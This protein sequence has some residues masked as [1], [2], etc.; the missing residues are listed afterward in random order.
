MQ[1]ELAFASGG[2]RHETG[3]ALE[4]SCRG[5]AYARKGCNVLKFCFKSCRRFSTVSGRA[6]EGQLCERTRKGRNSASLRA[7]A[8]DTRRERLRQ[9]PAGQV[10]TNKL[11]AQISQAYVLFELF[12]NLQQFS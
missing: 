12:Q 7:G 2:A 6:F 4:G 10:L 5:G 1:A 3:A 11:V 8:R 9:N